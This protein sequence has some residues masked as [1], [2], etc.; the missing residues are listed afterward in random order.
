MTAVPHVIIDDFL[1][2]ETHHGLL[3]HVLA[4]GDF[5][6]GKVQAHGK[7]DHAPDFRRGLHSDDRLGSFEKPFRSAVNE[8]LG[9]IR[10]GLAMPPFD[11]AGFEIQLIAHNDGDF[12]AAHR[13]VFT[14]KDR[15][16]T[17]GDRVITLVYYFHRQP[18]GFSGG[19]LRIFPFGAQPPLTVEPRDNRLIAFPSLMMH[20]VLPTVVPDRDFANSRF[21]VSCWI[22]RVR[23]DAPQMAE[24]AA[25]A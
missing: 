2:E 9:D 17:P 1:P 15:L 7:H 23:P 13:D 20:E 24:A 22:S 18:R 3:A 25:T 14:G 19:E 12:Y 4:V 11:R 16:L 10:T 21:S 5:V 8:R 6:P